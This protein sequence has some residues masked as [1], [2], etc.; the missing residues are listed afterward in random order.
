MKSIALVYN[1]LKDFTI[2]EI[3]VKNEWLC[4]FILYFIQMHSNNCQMVYA[5]LVFVDTQQLHNLSQ[6]TEFK[7]ASRTPKHSWSHTRTKWLYF[8]SVFLELGAPTHL[9]EV[10]IK[11]EQ[12]IS[13]NKPQLHVMSSAS[14]YD[15]L[16]YSMMLLL[17]LR[18]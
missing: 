5:R 10:F 3:A 8:C 15:I 12:S 9:L 2:L 4:L 18:N 17:A 6:A 16:W 1:S 14:E 11:I 13:F 7:K